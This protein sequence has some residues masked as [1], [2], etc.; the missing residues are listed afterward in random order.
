MMMWRFALRNLLRH[1]L[2]TSLTL[3]AVVFGVVGLTLSGGFVRDIFFQLGEGAIHSRL[4]HVQIAK[5]GYYEFG[6]RDP[7]RYLFD[8]PGE[9]E[10]RLREVPEVVEAMWRVKFAGLLNNG[11]T[12]LPIIGEGVEADKEARLGSAMTIIEG[13]QLRDADDYGILLGEGAAHSLELHPGD[14]ATLVVTSAGGALNT[15][16]FKVVGV[17]RTMSRDYDARAV[18][19][20]LA[21]AQDL[22]L[23]ERAHLLVLRLRETT[24]TDRVVA[25]L[26]QMLPPDRYEVRPWY[27]LAD[28]YRKTVALY[29]RQ[30]GL[31]VG[32]VMIMVLLGVANSVNMTL[33]E[34]IGECGTIMALGYRRRAVFRMLVQENFLLGLLGG[35]V[36]VALGLLLAAMISW[37]GIPMPPPPN[38]SSGYIAAIRPG[39]EMITLA[40]FV[41][42]FATLLASL[43]S[44]RRVV[45]IPVVDALRHNG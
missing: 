35:V 26:R 43:W 38:M 21:A 11:R 14:Y 27:E 31:L 40:F 4:G 20:G 32:I 18:R 44:A 15:V 30:F 6:R 10:T 41:G 24:A 23:D 34:R 28:F 3:G 13:R 37:V 5:R 36:G 17:M 1:R 22:L 2:R 39:V 42:V 9:L 7:Q 12:D 8:Q 25:A 45:R 16:D 19:I 33:F 29:E